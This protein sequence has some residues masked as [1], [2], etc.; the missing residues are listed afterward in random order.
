MAEII[1]GKA[2]ACNVRA[3]VRMLALDFEK[4]HGRKA[5]LAVVR[6]GSDP[7]SAVYVRNKIRACDECNIRSFAYELKE[8]V[9]Q[10]ELNELIVKLNNDKSVDG[11]IVQLPLP[12]HLDETATLALIS[13]DKDVDGFQSINAGKL[14]TGVKN[15]VVACTPRGIMELIKST[16]VKIAGKHAVVVGRSNIVGKPI[17]MLLLAADATVTVCHSKTDDLSSYTK[18]ADILVVAVGRKNFI[19]A[20]MVKRGAV[21]IDV[22][23]N[24]DESGLHG[25]VDFDTVKSVAGYITPVPGGVG[26]MTVAMLLQN[27][28]DGAFRE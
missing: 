19:S 11:I 26:P 1:D 14:F 27:T 24:R 8:D 20:D 10:A 21:V 4:K 7:A 22:G 28:V 23:I 16:G 18:T 15:G 9:T 6:V 12:K 25:D 5:G 13:P 17:A 2:I 3:A